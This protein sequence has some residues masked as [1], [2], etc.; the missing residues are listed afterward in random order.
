M[1]PTDLM[2]LA[3]VMLRRSMKHKRFVGIAGGRD[4][5]AVPDSDRMH[6]DAGKCL[7]LHYSYFARSANRSAAMGFAG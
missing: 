4:A 7:M 6:I 2:A 5:Q 3:E 1:F